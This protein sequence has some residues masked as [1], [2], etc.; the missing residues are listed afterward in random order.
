VKEVISGGLR[1][2]SAS[3]SG[4]ISLFLRISATKG[5]NFYACVQDLFDEALSPQYGTSLLGSVGIKGNVLRGGIVLSIILPGML[6]G[7]TIIGF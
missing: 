4:A 2:K 7:A 3:R 5:I 6:L 1:Q